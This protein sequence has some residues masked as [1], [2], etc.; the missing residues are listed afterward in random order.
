MFDSG[1]QIWGVE[2]LGKT[3]WLTDKPHCLY[4]L[5]H[6]LQ[7]AVLKACH[8]GL[9]RENS[10]NYYICYFGTEEL[11]LQHALKSLEIKQPSSITT[12]QPIKMLLICNRNFTEELAMWGKG[13]GGALQ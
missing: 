2:N 3:T 11:E 5:T 12:S 7:D 10:L 4:N 1:L 9:V 13:R 6:I 8:S